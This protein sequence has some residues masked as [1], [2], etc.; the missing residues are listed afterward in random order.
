MS[1]V[2][3]IVAWAALVVGVA[4]ACI[5]ARRAGAELTYLRDLVHV[6]AGLWV[7]GWPMWRGRAWPIAFALLG[8]A[9]T[10]VVP[11][12]A[13]RVG[14]LG[15]F[16]D[17]ISDASERWSSVG[18]YGLS[19]ATFTVIGF[20]GSPLPAGAGLLA[21]A[22]G[23]GLGGLAG[24]RYGRHFFTVPGAKRKTVE[25]TAAVALFAGLATA[26][27]I[28]RF[29]APLRPASIAAAALAA[30]AAEAGAPQGTD[31]LLVPAAVWI[32]LVAVQGVTP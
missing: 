28:L 11:A 12:L 6:G 27:A 17:S 29:G 8:A 3:L 20:T 24:R 1:D 9:A 19:F 32:A 31:N 5:A 2:A 23:D 14:A 15:R 25:G 22:L 4:A 26:L 21:L 7:L 16:R 18:L 13:G 10:Y 30:A